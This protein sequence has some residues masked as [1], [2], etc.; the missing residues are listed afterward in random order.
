MDAVGVRLLE[1]PS[2]FGLRLSGVFILATSGH[3]LP[4]HFLQVE[5]GQMGVVLF[6][7]QKSGMSQTQRLH[8]GGHGKFSNTVVRTPSEHWKT[9]RSSNTEGRFTVTLL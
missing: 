9:P 2:E 3:S 6:F 7:L 4:Q 8:E 5:D 1:Q